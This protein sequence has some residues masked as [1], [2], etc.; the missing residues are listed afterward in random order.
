MSLGIG[1]VMVS[2]GVGDV[3]GSQRVDDMM[4]SQGVRDVSCCPCLIG[5]GGK[6]R[7]HTAFPSLLQNVVPSLYPKTWV[8]CER[9]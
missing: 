2:Q 7:V 8:Q 3:I 1:E 5:F 6:W 9:G 4:V